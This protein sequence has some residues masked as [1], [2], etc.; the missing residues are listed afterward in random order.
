MKPSIITKEIWPEITREAKAG[1]NKAF[2]AVAYFGKGGAEMLPLISG[3]CLVVDASELAVKTGQTSPKE[4]MKLY[5]KGVSIYSYPRLHAKVFVL[6]SVLFIGSTNVS[7]N[8]SGNLQEAVLKTSDRK[9]I[10]QAKRFVESLCISEL[11]YERL[12]QLDKIYRPPIIPGWKKRKEPHK[13]V[14]K[15][16]GIPNFFVYRISNMLDYSDGYEEPLEQGRKEAERK[17]IKKSR[18]RIQEIQWAGKMP[19]KEGDVVVMLFRDYGIEMIYPP[20]TIINIKKWKKNSRAF[21]F[22]EIPDKEE[23]SIKEVTKR[24]DKSIFKRSGKKDV[25]LLS[26]ISRLWNSR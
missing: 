8:S 12:K 6:N 19:F 7:G 10:E 26:K 3:S 5:D 20:G 13:A 1:K 21:I 24:I 23:K 25:A 2:V 17:R 18:H 22:I 15:D 16:E 9:L 4:L 11:G 14:S